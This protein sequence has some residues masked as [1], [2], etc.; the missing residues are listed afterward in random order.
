[1]ATGAKLFGK[2]EM[3]T[4]LTNVAKNYSEK[5]GKAL[6][7]EMGIELREVVRR[8]PVLTGALR[9]TEK[10]IGPSQ[11]GKSIVVLIVAGGSEAPYA[12]V[13]HEDLEAFHKVGQAK[14]IESVLLESRGAIGSRVAARLHIA[15]WVN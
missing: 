7:I 8:T 3:K 1:M 12:V 9:K 10:L 14:Y 15:D 4:K 11:Q 6:Y 5:V 2:T 13:V